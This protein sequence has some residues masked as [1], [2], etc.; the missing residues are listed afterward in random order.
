VFFQVL[1]AEGLALQT[2]R[3][4]TYVWPQQT[5]GCIGC[6][7]PRDEAP[8]VGAGRPLALL[9]E[10]S[11]LT[12]GPDGS[13]PLHFDRLVQPVLD[14]HCV[15]CHGAG[16]PVAGPPASGHARAA[17]LNLTSGRSYRSLLVCAS[18]N[19]WHLVREKNRSIVGDCPARQS[20]ILAAL[21]SSPA[22]QGLRLDEDSLCRLVTWM[23]L[24]A[25][26]RGDFSDQQAEELGALKR[27]LKHLIA[28]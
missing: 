17:A 24:Y 12:A 18:S 9:R 20:K 26:T 6:H 13:W 14:R 10:P 15:S 19:L 11:R 4:L 21:R 27:K 25:P 8:S 1:D 3:T 23:D 28:P 7:E 22:H 2:M 16:P 5:L